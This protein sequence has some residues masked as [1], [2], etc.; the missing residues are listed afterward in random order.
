MTTPSLRALVVLLGLLALPARIAAQSAG[1]SAE[2]G[3]DCFRCK[4]GG[5]CAPGEH[6][7]YPWFWSNYLHGTQHYN[8]VPFG[9]VHA[10]YGSSLQTIDD[11]K[12]A[13]ELGTDEGWL[14]VLRSGLEV[15]VVAHRNAIQVLSEAGDVVFHAP[16]PRAQALRLQ[17]VLALSGASSGQ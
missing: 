9:C 16:I 4:L 5:A 1:Q 7:D 13:M 6:E 11:A 14:R 17:P 2:P 12:A 10:Q 8:C 15:R 3:E